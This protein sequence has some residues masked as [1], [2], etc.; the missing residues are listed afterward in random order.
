MK[1]WLVIIILLFAATCFAEATATKGP[2]G[3]GNPSIGA[4]Q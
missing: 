3:V 2:Q 1:T 4:Y